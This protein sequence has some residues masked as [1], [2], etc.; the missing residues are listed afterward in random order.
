MDDLVRAW[1]R[2]RYLS[3]L[4]APDDMRPHLMALYA[5]DAEVARVSTL[6]SEPAI[7]E[8]RLQWW[9]DTLDAIYEKA[10]VDHPVAKALAAAIVRGRLPKEPLRNLVLARTRELYADPMPSLN[11]LEGYLGET[12]SAVLQMAAQIMLDGKGQGLGTF[13][14]LAGVA[15]GIGEL[16]VK[17]PK[18]PHG[19]RHLLPD[20]VDLLAH[21]ERRL[22]DSR[23]HTDNIHK[24]VWPACLPLCTA[25]KRL[26][27]LKKKGNGA[28]ISPLSGPWLIWRGSKFFKI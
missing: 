24:N 21:A 15:Q 22:E 14:G 27:V 18:L 20:G 26:N 28:D 4:F 19:G 3:T 16:L 23:Q 11:D 2:D 10:D 13:S 25:Q 9:L 17:Q 1:S 5:F 7:G 8:I 12:N 6:V